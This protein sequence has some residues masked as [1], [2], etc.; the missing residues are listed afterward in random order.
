MDPSARWDDPTTIVLRNQGKPGLHLHK[1]SALTRLALE[2]A[3]SAAISVS[4]PS[5]V[6]EVTAH[7]RSFGFGSVPVAQ[8][9]R[10]RTTG[11]ADLTIVFDLPAGRPLRWDQPDVAG[12]F[13]IQM[14]DL[15]DLA[16]DG[17]LWLHLSDAHRF[18]PWRLGVRLSDRRVAAFRIPVPE[19]PTRAYLAA[20]RSFWRAVRGAELVMVETAAQLRWMQAA[21]L[22]AVLFP[23][24]LAGAAP[25]SEPPDG[26]W[27]EVVRR[28]DLLRA[29]G[30]RV[31]GV[32]GRAL[33]GKKGTLGAVAAGL[34][35]DDGVA[36]VLIGAD[37]GPQGAPPDRVVCAGSERLEEWAYLE[38]LGRCDVLL[39]VPAPTH[40]LLHGT[41]S[42]ADA[43]ALRKPLI[44]S[45]HL[46]DHPLLSFATG[47]PTAQ[48]QE[49]LTGG[50]LDEVVERGRRFDWRRWDPSAVAARLVAGAP[51]R[52]PGPSPA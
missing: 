18:L 43:I 28:I 29:R 17:R 47:V 8:H 10:T 39:N 52:R 15:A 11:G 23:G 45:D 40:P 21:G 41:G 51:P 6:D 4:T 26:T 5:E 49:G 7:L 16:T 32:T 22:P 37:T 24:R 9:E 13:V 12:G 25:T 44:T 33:K 48:L 31:I 30:L 19:V 20:R 34:R 3:P 1:V 27:S 42:I 50:M 46:V 2:M 14:R 35:R 38:V 36:F